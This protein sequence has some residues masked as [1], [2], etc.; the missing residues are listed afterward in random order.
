[1]THRTTLVIADDHP[2]V[3]Y[4]LAELIRLEPEFDILAVCADGVDAIARIRDLTPDMAVLDL[5]MP[6]KS[7]LEIL[8]E[9]RADALSTRIVLLTAG[10]SD[11]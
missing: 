10:I 2:L 1:M 9:I 6:G 3:L 11:S 8:R 4:G 7:G 5:N